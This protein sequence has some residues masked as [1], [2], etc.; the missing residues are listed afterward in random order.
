MCVVLCSHAYI[1]IF[2]QYKSLT[3]ISTV[4]SRTNPYTKETLW[5]VVYESQYYDEVYEEEG[6]RDEDEVNLKAMLAGERLKI[7]YDRLRKAAPRSVALN[8]SPVAVAGGPVAVPGCPVPVTYSPSVAVADCPFTIARVHCKCINANT[9]QLCLAKLQRASAFAK[10]H[11][12]QLYYACSKTRILS[13]GKAN[14]ISPI[15]TLFILLTQFYLS[16]SRSIVNS[17]DY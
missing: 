9:G 3:C 11:P 17:G 10:T 15:Y 12:N 16:Y 2:F 4:G 6:G 1:F 5:T 14:V 8:G 13:D 7:E